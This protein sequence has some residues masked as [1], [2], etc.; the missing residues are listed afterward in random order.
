MMRLTQSSNK[1]P[2]AYAKPL[3]KKGLRCKKGYDEHVLKG[4]LIGRYLESICH[5]M[6]SYW[7]LKKNATVHALDCHLTSFAKQR[8]AD[9][10]QEYFVPHVKTGSPQHMPDLEAVV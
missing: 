9:A 3:C 8:Q 4:V 10:I 7:I 1:S 5:S 2:T 6:C